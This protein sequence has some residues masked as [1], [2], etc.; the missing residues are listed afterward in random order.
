MMLPT[1][2][3]NGTSREALLEQTRTAYGAVQDALEAV[4]Q[5]AANARDYYVQGPDAYNTA[6]REHDERLDRLRSVMTELM[7]IFVELDV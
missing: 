1:V 2:H 6:R 5:A 3:L 4:A 7:Y